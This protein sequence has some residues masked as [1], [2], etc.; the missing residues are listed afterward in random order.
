MMGVLNDAIV[1]YE[2]KVAGLSASGNHDACGMMPALR[3][4]KSMAISPIA[5]EARLSAS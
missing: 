1:K 3:Q 4:L 5:A 2:L